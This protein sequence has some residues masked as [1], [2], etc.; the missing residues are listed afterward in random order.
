MWD[1]GIPIPVDRRF[2]GSGSMWLSSIA[3][4]FPP[5]PLGE[6]AGMKKTARVI[7]VPVQKMCLLSGVF[8]GEVC[9]SYL[10]VISRPISL[11]PN[12]AGSL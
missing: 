6:R 7:V 12:H 8:V 3:P 10:L 1:L 2:Y 5:A 11:L 4:H 9:R